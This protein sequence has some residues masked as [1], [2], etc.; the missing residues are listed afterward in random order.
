MYYHDLFFIRHCVK[1]VCIRNYSGPHFL[2]F[3]LN[4]ERYSE[5]YS[6]NADQNDSEY[7]LRSVHLYLKESKKDHHH[8]HHH[9][10]HVFPWLK[11]CVCIWSFTQKIFYLSEK[12]CYNLCLNLTTTLF[13]CS[14]FFHL[15]ILYRFLP[16]TLFQPF[17]KNHKS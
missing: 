4:T 5:R 6:E 13:H 8:F 16:N 1:S 9:G 17:L 10:H 12:H 3:G 7:F 14:C 2:A 11:I 15:E